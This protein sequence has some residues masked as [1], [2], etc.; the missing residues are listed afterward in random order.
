MD[1]EK[2]VE[3][4]CTRIDECLSEKYDVNPA[5]PNE[6]GRPKGLVILINNLGSLS[7][8]QMLEVQHTISEFLFH[9]GGNLLSRRKFPIHVYSGALMTAFETFGVSISCMV[10]HQEHRRQLFAL[11]AET[12]ASAWKNGFDLWPSQNHPQMRLTFADSCLEV[13]LPTVQI[14]RPTL[15]DEVPMAID[16]IGAP[17]FQ[18]DAPME[19]SLPVR[20]QDSGSV[21]ETS[22]VPRSKSELCVLQV[23]R[24]LADNADAIGVLEE[25]AG[26]G[27]LRNECKCIIIFP[28]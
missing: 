11:T 28:S 21:T 12:D 5:A 26:N 10:L 18:D 27:N 3:H 14:S 6:D 22:R 24:A 8:T 7:P 1:N 17:T 23:A 16:E 20:Q 15:H 13:L 2:I 19:H 4:M 9:K 25:R